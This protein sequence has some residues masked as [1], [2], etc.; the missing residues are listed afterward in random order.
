MNA[1]EDPVFNI[2]MSLFGWVAL[3]VLLAGG[4]YALG[5]SHTINELYAERAMLVIISIMAIGLVIGL[6]VLFIFI[7]RQNEISRV[8]IQRALDIRYPI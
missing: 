5:A 3:G 2:W 4:S 1:G 7:K 8:R 6:I